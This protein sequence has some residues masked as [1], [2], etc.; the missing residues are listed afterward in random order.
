MLANCQKIEENLAYLLKFIDFI[1]QLFIKHYYTATDC[2]NWHFVFAVKE[3]SYVLVNG[4]N[5]HHST[6]FTF[7]KKRYEKNCLDLILTKWS[8]LVYKRILMV[9]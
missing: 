2:T 8:L 5:L 4:H 7:E 1:L 9:I 3:Y 6:L